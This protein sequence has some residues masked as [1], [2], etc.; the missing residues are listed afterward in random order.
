M[1]YTVFF[2]VAQASSAPPE[3]VFVSVCEMDPVPAG[4]STR[5]A[6]FTRPAYCEVPALR[7]TESVDA[8]FDPRGNYFLLEVPWGA[9]P[10]LMDRINRMAD[11]CGLSQF[12][13]QLQDVEVPETWSD[14]DSYAG[15]PDLGDDGADDDPS[16]IVL[17]FDPQAAGTE[18][19]H[20]YSEIAAVSHIAAND[21]P[22]RR[23]GAPRPWTQRGRPF[24]CHLT[25]RDR[26]T[27]G[28]HP[29]E[30]GR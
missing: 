18:G 15:L 27:S 4:K 12:D 24:S 25:Q 6:Q 13:P 2:Y 19:R 26:G 5:V 21:C 7:D 8:S 14:E 11:A 23:G 28:P 20:V 17:F 29:Y 30:F 1:G 16:Y 22:A 9:A 10:E 3:V